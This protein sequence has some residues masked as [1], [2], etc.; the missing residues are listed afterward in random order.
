MK[1][2]KNQKNL[3][4]LLSL[5][6]IFTLIWVASNIYHKLN[7]STIDIPLEASIIPIEGSFD[8]KTIEDIKSRKRV[9]PS[10]DIILLPD[11]S[12][13]EEQ[14]ATTSAQLEVETNLESATES[15]E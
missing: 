14:T 7:T 8:K 3:I 9:E 4:I 13:V 2:K 11:D 5:I 15:A 1:N 6:L 10:N 12:Q